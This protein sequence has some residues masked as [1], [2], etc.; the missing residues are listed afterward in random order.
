[1]YGSGPIAGIDHIRIAKN[2]LYLI[3]KANVC[4]VEVLFYAILIIA[5]GIVYQ[6]VA[7]QLQRPRCSM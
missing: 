5:M 2:L 6:P 3:Y 7:I 1:M 4:N